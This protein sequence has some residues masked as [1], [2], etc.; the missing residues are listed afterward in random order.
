[1]LAAMKITLRLVVAVLLIVSASSYAGAQGA[2]F[3][4]TADKALVAMRHKAEELN[5]QGAAI[6][7]YFEGEKIQAWSSKMVVVGSMKTEPKDATDPGS[8]LLAFAYA[9]ACE[10]A[11]TLKDSGSNSRPV[12]KGELGWQGGVIVRGKKGYIVAAFSGGKSEDDVK[13]SRAGAEAMQTAF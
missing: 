2:Q 4:A 13:V 10:M 3:D 12:M 5:I 11:D 8:N 6:V 1:M 7:A 9:K